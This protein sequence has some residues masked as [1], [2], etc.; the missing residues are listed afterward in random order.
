MPEASYNKVILMGRL[1]RD[2]EIRS[3]GGAKVASFSVATT[4][5]WKDGDGRRQERS[6]FHPVAIWNQALIEAV[7]PH[8]KKGSRIHLE[9][10]LEHRSY[11]G[12][13]ATRYVTEIVLRNF[14]GSIEM[15]DRAPARPAEEARPA[16]RG[17][18][19]SG[20]R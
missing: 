14:N 19:P 13:Q 8:L 6:Q 9:G 12:E 16:S 3:A 15:V 7:V 4:D 11:E 1:T 5:T 18:E 20:R 2:P 10:S 17:A